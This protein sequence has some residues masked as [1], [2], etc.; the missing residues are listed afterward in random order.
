MERNGRRFCVS[1]RVVSSVFVEDFTYL[2]HL[3][4]AALRNTNKRMN[5]GLY[6]QH[7]SHFKIRSLRNKGILK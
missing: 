5:M 6:Y 7:S 2:T 1:L 3:E 4:V